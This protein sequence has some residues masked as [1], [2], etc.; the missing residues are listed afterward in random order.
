M[1]KLS[2]FLAVVLA[3]VCASCLEAGRQQAR[4]LA[5]WAEFHFRA[6]RTPGARS[7]NLVMSTPAM[8]EQGA[9]IR[10]LFGLQPDNRNYY[11]VGVI[12][13]RLTLG[14]V[15]CGVELPL[16]EWRGPEG[17]PAFATAQEVTVIRRPGKI[18]VAVGSRKIIK[19][20]DDTYTQGTAAVGARDMQSALRPS[21]RGSRTT[22][23]YA[24]DDFMRATDEAAAWRPVSGKWAIESVTNPGLSANAFVYSGRAAGDGPAAAVLG[25]PWWDDYTFEVSTKPAGSSGAGLLFRY[26]DAKNHYVFRQSGK[27]AGGALQL[28]R[29]EGGLETIL[30]QTAGR[31]R[32][33]QWARLRVTALGDRLAAYVDEHRLFEVDDAGPAFGMVGLYV[34]GGSGA[35]FDDVFVRGNR[36]IVEDFRSGRITWRAK[37]G[38]WTVPQVG[39]PPLLAGLGP[40][41]NST[42]EFG[43]LLGGG[44][45]RAD[46]RVSVTVAPGAAGKL[47]IVTRYRDE[48]EHD[49]FVYDAVAGRYEFAV[50][51]DGEPRVVASAPAKELA[52]PRR[53]SVRIVGG[54]TVCEADGLRMLSH[55]DA[56]APPGKVG[57]CV[58]RESSASFSDLSVAF[59][60]ESRPVLTKLDTFAAETTM[61]NWAAAKSDWKLVGTT[62]WGKE[63]SVCWHRGGFPGGGAIQ[64]GALFDSAKGGTL[65]LF[66]CCDVASG[67]SPRE[68][69][70]GYELEVRSSGHGGSGAATL[71]RNGREVASGELEGL[72]SNCRVALKKVAD[73]VVAEINDEAVLAF[74]DKA[75]LG[76]W[77]TGCA[78]SDVQVKPEDVDVFCKNTVSYSFVRAAADWRTAGGDWL[79]TNR[80]R[81]DPRWSFFGGE[82]LRGVAAIWH[83]SRLSG[84]LSVEFAAGIR[85]QQRGGG[86]YRHA[87]DMNVVICGNGADLVSGYGFVLGGWGNTKTAITRNGKIVAE[88]ER[89]IPGSIHR[90]WFYFKVVKRGGHLKYYI[91]EELVLEYTDP[92]PLPDGR[93]AL[94][95]WKNGLMVA[96]VRIAADRIGP[97]ERFDLPVPAVSKCMY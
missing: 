18:A 66:I 14:K 53:L 24:A 94:W 73:Y 2:C 56:A 62:C 72:L 40:A 29:V 30:K 35:E 87:S 32:P 76:G 43:K 74:K 65:R 59:P 97:N 57:L 13:D 85:H 47:G 89:T 26:V 6:L 22:E 63:H 25:E 44:N 23:I 61:A 8:P 21:V 55:F 46:C 83:K 9:E 28:V 15:E 93:V 79:V 92:N 39:G 42:L 37:G 17:G 58:G 49:R 4:V 60:E 36:G 80:W 71:R 5:P 86:S 77:W 10:L 68:V 45:A 27:P 38:K 69:R 54:V 91:D 11:F 31:L 12:R 33:G 34:D 64:V 95:T 96:R 78:P 82:S 41:G 3:M 67:G 51:R 52:S 75:P 88:I 19:V 1:R 16:A 48:S 70:S 81:C 84:D 90:R 7:F 20:S 50:V